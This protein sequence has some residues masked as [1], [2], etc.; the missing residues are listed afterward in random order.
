MSSRSGKI[1]AVETPLTEW[2]VLSPELRP[3]HKDQYFLVKQ[4]GIIFVLPPF[5]DLRFPIV[6]LEM[7]SD[8]KKSRDRCDC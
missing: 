3:K 1:I 2:S 7:S 4:Y 8:E 5:L 6:E